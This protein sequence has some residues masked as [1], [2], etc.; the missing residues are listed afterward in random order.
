M[1]DLSL[2]VAGGIKQ[3]TDYVRLAF[4]LLQYE[5]NTDVI[6]K[7]S[8]AADELFLCQ[9]LNF[10]TTIVSSITYLLPSSVEY[11]AAKKSKISLSRERFPMSNCFGVRTLWIK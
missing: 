7:L 2:L 11:Q 1:K 3:S 9:Q 8:S 4:E 10:K 6:D 5:L